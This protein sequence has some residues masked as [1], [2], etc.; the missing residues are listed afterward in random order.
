MHDYLKFCAFMAGAIPSE[1][2]N[3][4][5]LEFFDITSGGFSGSIPF[6]IFNI[7]TILYIGLTLNNLYGHLPSTMGNFLPNLQQLYLG[8]NQLSGIIPSSISNASQL[9]EIELAYN[10]FSGLIPNT[11]DNL[12]FLRLLNLQSNNLT[13]ESSAPKLSFFSTLSNSS[14]LEIL[15]LSDNPLNGILPNSVGNL[16]TSLQYFGIGHCNINGNIPIEIENLS[17]LTTLFLDNNH[18]AGPIPTTVGKLHKLQALYLQNNKL[19]GSIPSE[20]CNL[21]SLVEYQ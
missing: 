8:A 7:S 11:L 14:Y 18:F 3:L 12:R 17:S 5:N 9:S 19:E 10:S 6:E 4:Q 1:I 16:S 2:G 13:I 21:E 20:L 15:V